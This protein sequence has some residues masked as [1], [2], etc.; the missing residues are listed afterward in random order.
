[1]SLL[2]GFAPCRTPLDAPTASYYGAAQVAREVTPVRRPSLTAEAAAAARAEAAADS[3][4]RED[5]EATP[6]PQARALVHLRAT[7]FRG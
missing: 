7:L 3:D 1:M 4:D 6:G 2:A 5:E